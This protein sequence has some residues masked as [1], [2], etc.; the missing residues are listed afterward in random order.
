MKKSLHPAS[1]AVQSCE[2]VEYALGGKC[3]FHGVEEIEQCQYDGGTR[4]AEDEQGFLHVNG[5]HIVGHG[6]LEGL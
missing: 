3:R 2:L 1:R 5:L 6:L 4:D